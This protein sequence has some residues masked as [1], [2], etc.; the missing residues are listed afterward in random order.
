[1]GFQECCL[2]FGQTA[3]LA[4]FSNYHLGGVLLFRLVASRSLPD[5]HHSRT[6]RFAVAFNRVCQVVLKAGSSKLAV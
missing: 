1:M 3:H 6:F 4:E 5:S 2:G